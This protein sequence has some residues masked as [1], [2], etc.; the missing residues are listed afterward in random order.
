MA[1]RTGG[2]EIGRGKPP[3]HSC[4]QKGRSGNPG[5]RKKNVPNLKT[6]INAVMTGWVEVSENGRTRKISVV[7]AILLRQVQEALRGQARA[8]ESLLDR[9]ERCAGADESSEPELPEDDLA[10]LDRVLGRSRCGQGSPPSHG[11]SGHAEDAPEPDVRRSVEPNDLG[12][13]WSDE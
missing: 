12:E 9:F 2:Y 1:S 13:E 4:F 6:V 3:K 11:G 7:E 8:A 10:L 5:G